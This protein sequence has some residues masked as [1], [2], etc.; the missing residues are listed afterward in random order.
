MRSTPAQ[1]IGRRSLLRA[2]CV[3]PLAALTG[4][5]TG[6]GRPPARLRIATGAS[7]GV[8]Y[9]YGGGVAAVIQ[10]ELP[11]LRPEVMVTAASIENLSLVADGVAEVGFALAD[12]SAL[13]YEGQE[14]FG[15]ALAIAA[16]ANLYDNYLHVVV[17]TD[18][19]LVVLA[20]LHGR[21]VSLGP[22]GSGTELI[23]T[24]LLAAVGLDADRDLTTNRLGLDESARAL[25]DGGLDAFFFSGG[26]PTAAIAALSRTMP[27]SLLDLGLFVPVMRERH[28][29]VYTQRTI[30]A[31]AYGLGSPVATIGVANYLV[32]AEAMAETVS[33]DV[34]DVMFANRDRLALAHPEGRRLDRVSAINTSPLPLHPGARRYY[35]EAKR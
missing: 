21:A 1:P 33:H 35:R 28:G 18:R 7:G 32:V 3:V 24:R 6:P 34:L 26:I 4:C 17:R 22:N 12:S 9:A 10:Q 13:A 19:D 16:L 5:E 23:A 29:D 27:I 8:Y 31:S 11:W 15:Q 25:A 30:P 20:D 2:A 14:P